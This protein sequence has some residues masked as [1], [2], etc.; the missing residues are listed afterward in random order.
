MH[1]SSL[2]PLPLIS[3]LPKCVNHIW[4]ADDASRGGKLDNL[5]SWSNKIQ[6]VGPLFG[7][8]PNARKSWLLVKEE[9]LSDAE[10]VFSGSGVNITMEEKSYL[11][12]L[13]GTTSSK[14]SAIAA[15]VN[16]W[17]KEID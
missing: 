8:F 14:E 5:R 17:V 15:K 13:L 2:M 4:Y 10:R 16:Q 9:F 3:K 7:Y 12:A 1:L 6:E 11:G